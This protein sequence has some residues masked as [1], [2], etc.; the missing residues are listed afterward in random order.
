[1]NIIPFMKVGTSQLLHRKKSSG[2]TKVKLMLFLHVC[3]KVALYQGL[4]VSFIAIKCLTNYKSVYI[5]YFDIEFIS[6]LFLS[7]H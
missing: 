7:F 5:S 4:Q 2:L 3:I 1:M 6:L